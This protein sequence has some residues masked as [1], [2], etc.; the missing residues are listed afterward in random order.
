M[1]KKK[2]LGILV[3]TS[4]MFIPLLS[5]ARAALPPEIQEFS[6]T[7]IGTQ[8]SYSLV[9]TLIKAATGTSSESIT[10]LFSKFVG[11]GSD[12]ILV[13]LVPEATEGYQDILGEDALPMVMK[14]GLAGVVEDGVMAMFNAHPR[15][16]VIAHL[17]DEWVPGHRQQQSVY[18]SGYTD[19][20]DSGIHVLWA[21]TRNIAYSGFVLIMIVI[22]FMI[23]FR[24]KIGGQTL[25]TIGNSIPKIVVG[26]ILVTFSFAIAGI[27]LDISGIFL[28]VISGLLE[29]NILIHNPFKLLWG[30]ITNHPEF[31]GL[32]GALG[33]AGIVML[34]ATSWGVA[35]LI[36]LFL[37]V[38][39]AGVV[40]IGA[41]KLWFALLKS[42]FALLLNLTVAPLVIMAGSLPGDSVAITNLFKSML[43]NALVFPVA[44]AIVNLP[45]F[46]ADRQGILL[47][48]PSSVFPDATADLRIG[49][50]VIG[51]AKILAIYVAA[52]TPSF[53]KA[54]IPATASRA[55]AD[56]AAAVKEGFSKIPMIGGMFK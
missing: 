46:L 42:Y 35:G 7:P 21:F 29:T 39:V 30:M 49:G 20:H 26:L 54:I 51:I 16:D 19:L 12:V 44:Y 50:L 17:A 8:K 14:R 33:I 37:G 18:A 41:I 5:P 15:I 4:L 23:M 25:V 13:T 52:Q 36:A 10:Q 56:S 32:S 43:R 24:N 6:E 28:R 9:W 38:V 31:A 45:Y 55:G 47:G 40:I 53:M 22:G 48:F 2:I 11:G 34:I 27:I 1:N 3:I